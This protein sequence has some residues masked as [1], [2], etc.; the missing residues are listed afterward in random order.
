MKKKSISALVQCFLLHELCFLTLTAAL[1]QVSGTC[2]LICPV[3]GV[4]DQ[5]VSVPELCA[6]SPTV[7]VM[8]R[9]LKRDF[10]KA[11]SAWHGALS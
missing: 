6:P 9:F 11:V 1:Q 10:P 3:Y 2:S 7:L 5:L 8:P 4:C